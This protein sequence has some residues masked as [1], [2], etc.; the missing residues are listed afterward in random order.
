VK[1]NSY[2]SLETVLYDVGAIFQAYFRTT[3]CI[4]SRAGNFTFQNHEYKYTTL[5]DEILSNPLCIKD[6]DHYRIAMP[7]RALC[8]YLYLYPRA[9]LDNPEAFDNLNAKAR[10]K[11]LFPLYPKTTQKAVRKLLHLSEI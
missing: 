1:N 10:L 3:T 9:S 4:A 7:E 8:D 5:K 6:Y 2:I 11:K